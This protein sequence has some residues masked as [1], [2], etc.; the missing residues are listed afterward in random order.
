MNHNK[1]IS[2]Y[3]S[4]SHISSEKER[5]PWNFLLVGIHP[6][7]TGERTYDGKCDGKGRFTDVCGVMTSNIK[8]HAGASDSPQ[9]IQGLLPSP[10]PPRRSN[11]H[12]GRFIPC[13]PSP[14][15][16]PVQIHHHPQQTLCDPVSCQRGARGGMEAETRDTRNLLLLFPSNTSFLCSSFS[17]DETK[18]ITY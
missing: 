8:H 14:A 2:S 17:S 9:I 7:K 18:Y 13:S 5:K 1:I 3:Y 4:Y 15:E 12:S 10:S 11:A 6:L 16:R